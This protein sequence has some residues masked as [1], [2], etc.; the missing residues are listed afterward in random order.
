MQLVKTGWIEDQI[1]V[2]SHEFR[3][4][5]ISISCYLEIECDED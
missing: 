2:T 5:R 4:E 3:K 1:R